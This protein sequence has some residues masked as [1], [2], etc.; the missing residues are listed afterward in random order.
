MTVFHPRK[1][2]MGQPVEI[3]HPSRPTAFASWVDAAQPAIAIPGGD[4]PAIIN[5]IE[6]VRVA[7]PVDA[8]GWEKQVIDRT[9]LKAPPLANPHNKKLSAG[10]VIREEDGRV[11]LFEPTNRF[12]GYVRTFPKGT[13]EAGYSLA[14]TAAKEAFEEVGLLVEIGAPIAD[15]ERTTSVCRYFLAR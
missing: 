9:A 15:V 3:R 5:G 10:A 13:V 2:D 6:I 1:N 8:A 7:S 14:A 12:G 4:L 11:W